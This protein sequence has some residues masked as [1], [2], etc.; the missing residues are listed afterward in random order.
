MARQQIQLVG[1]LVAGL[2]VAAGTNAH[3]LSPSPAEAP[4]L[5]NRD[6]ARSRL[7]MRAMEGPPPGIEWPPGVIPPVPPPPITLEGVG[8]PAHSHVLKL[9]SDGAYTHVTTQFIP[10][11]KVPA[12]AALIE[13]LRARPRF[14]RDFPGGIKVAAGDVIG[15]GQDIGFAGDT[16]TEGAGLGYW[17]PGT[18]C[19]SAIPTVLSLPNRPEPAGETCYTTLATVGVFLNGVGLF[20]WSDA[21][22]YRSENVWH[23][24]ATVFEAHSLD[25]C[26][27]HAAEG[28][29]HH[30]GYSD[31]LAAEIGDAGGEHSPVWGYAADGYPIHGP[32][33]SDGELARSCWR[34]RDYSAGSAT[35]CGADNARS[36]QR[37][38]MF[39]VGKG[40][41][42]T[43]PA[44]AVDA[45]T[46]LSMF[47]ENPVVTKVGSYY[48]DHYWD[49]GCTRE[50][51]SALDQHNGHAHGDFGYH[52]HLTV[53][54]RMQPVFPY[55]FGP[56]YRGRLH[57]NGFTTCGPGPFGF[58]TRNIHDRAGSVP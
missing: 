56:T 43:K 2:T 50:G 24:S 58:P 9:I 51:G 10:D 49:P 20:N 54:S 25:V 45:T 14:S 38:D 34:S 19:A 44:P 27:G 1:I 35:G 13:S 6:G 18:F 46:E 31:C 42:P 40:T 23:N 16:C 11:Y 12:T 47:A 8:Q 28:I 15:F 26:S 22:S 37:V 3:Q 29:Y 39:D 32:W 36:C 17:P 48:Q 5:V 33:Q 4:W 52:Y 21:Q 41:R 53:D 55:S 30:H 7:V 57:D